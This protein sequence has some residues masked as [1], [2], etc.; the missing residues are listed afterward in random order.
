VELAA[1]SGSNL[2]S[3]G[4][5]RDLTSLVI[6]VVF[7]VM[8]GPSAA[9]VSTGESVAIGDAGGAH[10]VVCSACPLALPRW[11]TRSVMSAD[12]VAIRP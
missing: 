1:C 10:R 9:A 4:L 5:V 12:V 2:S 6:V 8:K 7:N 3:E 11:G